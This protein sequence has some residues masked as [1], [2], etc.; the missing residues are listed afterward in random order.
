MSTLCEGETDVARESPM[1]IWQQLAVLGIGS[2]CWTA[3][4]ADYPQWRG[5]ERNG[6]AQDTG[7]LKEWPEGG[8]ELLWQVKDLGSG[9]STPSVVGERIFLQN[10]RGMD[11][12]F[13][14]VLRV[15]DGS[16]IWSTRLGKVGNPDQKPPYAGARSTPTVD[17]AFVYALGSDGDLAC[18]TVETGEVQWSKN[19]RTDFGGVPGTWAYSESLLIDGEVLVCTPGGD[20]ATVVALQKQTGDVLWK[21][22]LPGGSRAAYASPTVIEVD[23]VEQYVVFLEAGLVG[24]K[25]ENG[26]LLWRYDRT[27]E[28][29]L[30]NMPTPVS[31]D[32]YVYSSSRQSGGGLIK[33]SRDDGMFTVREVY[34]GKKLPVSIGGAIRIDGFLYG[35]NS[36]GP[37]CVDFTTGEVQWQT[38]SIGASSLCY[39]DGRFYL[40]GEN[41]DVALIEATPKEYREAG[42]FTPPDQP[43]QPERGKSRAWA[44]PVVA[45]GRL[46][47]H[48]FGTLWCYDIRAP[49]S[50]EQ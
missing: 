18:L 16:P 39:A 17:G 33:L 48:D 7:L 2:L 23:G 50:Q 31:H 14:Q 22:A 34:F 27:A 47:L 44:Y 43:D 19:L 3:S 15:Q 26:T 28:G 11:N 37:L 30:N 46:Y 4:A 45:N 24:L 8:P 25:A 1:T 49:K 10:N 9:Y 20:E 29:S 5:P 13:V 42:R 38:R 21:F 41:G 6:I 12:E 40:H 36:Q 35:T 32:G